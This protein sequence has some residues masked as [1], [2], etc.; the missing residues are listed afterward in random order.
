MVMREAGEP[1]VE[2][3]TR[4]EDEGAGPRTPEPAWSPP[5][6]RGVPSRNTLARALPTSEVFDLPSAPGRLRV[7]EVRTPEAFAALRA[8]WNRLLTRANDQ[9]FYRHEVLSA[10]LTNFAPTA[11]LRVLTARGPHGRLSA[12]LPLV[13]GRGLCAGLPVRTL[14]SPTNAHSCRFDL[15]AEDAPVAGA[16]FLQYLQADPD[17]D[18]LHLDDVPHGGHAWSLQRAAEDAG[19]P[20]GSEPT[21]QSPYLLLPRSVA[22]LQAGWSKNLRSGVRRRM[23]R[24][25]EHGPVEVEQVRGGPQL[26]ER[27]AEGFELER[28]GWKGHQGTA[29]LQDPRTLGFYTQL[30]LDA[31]QGGYLSL[32]FLRSH[33]RAIAFDFALGYGRRYLSLKPAYDERFSVFSPGQLLTAATLESLVTQGLEECDLLGHATACK[34]AWADRLRPHS[35]LLV[36]RA[37]RLGRTLAAARLR[38]LPSVKGTVRRWLRTR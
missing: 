21:Q 29:I 23:K 27:L 38:W 25:E 26:A 7:Q 9:V 5:P 36:F 11:R 19:L 12:V 28:S 4:E 16:A 33:G 13:E 34:Q 20:V 10:W 37:T 1:Y 14:R 18:L 22:E 15:V 3:V 30:A 32:Y 35:R 6:P 31:A 24:L 17:W 2:P 8:D